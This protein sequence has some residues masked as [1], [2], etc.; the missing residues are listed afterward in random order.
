MAFLNRA[1]LEDVF[2][3]ARNK[4]ERGREMA[5]RTI[6]RKRVGIPSGPQLVFAFKPL[7][8]PSTIAG[9]TLQIFTSGPLPTGRGG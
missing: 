5:E 7:R 1:G 6:T 9:V 8:T 3:Q 2:K 4:M